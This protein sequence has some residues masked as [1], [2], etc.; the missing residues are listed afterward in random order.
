MEYL[1]LNN[2]GLSKTGPK[3]DWLREIGFRTPIKEIDIKNNAL[4]VPGIVEVTYAMR[5]A[6]GL[7]R[8]QFRNDKSKWPLNS[9]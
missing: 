9:R 4:G 5:E 7:E 1:A 8:I 6:K 2:V 3:L